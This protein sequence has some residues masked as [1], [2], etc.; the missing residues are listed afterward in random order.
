MFLSSGGNILPL[1]TKLY[2]SIGLK[3]SET[4]SNILKFYLKNIV[5]AQGPHCCVQAFSSCGAQAQ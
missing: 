4:G 2:K 3:V 5:A 1:A